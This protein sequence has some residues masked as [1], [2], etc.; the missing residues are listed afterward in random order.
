MTSEAPAVERKRFLETLVAKGLC[1][2]GKADVLWRLL[3]DPI[4]DAEGQAVA[5]GWYVKVRFIDD[6]PSEAKAYVGLMPRPGR[7]SS[8]GAR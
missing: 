5:R 2:R 7:L 1:S 3:E 4:G 8:G 6:S